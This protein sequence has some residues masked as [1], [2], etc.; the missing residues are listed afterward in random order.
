GI[1]ITIYSLNIVAWGGMLFLLLINAAPAMC[2]PSCNDISSSRRIWVEIDSQIL[3][4]LFCIPGFGLI[5]WRFRDLYLLMRYRIRGDT[6]AWEKLRGVHHTW[7]TWHGKPWKV[8]L[9]VHLYCFNT[10]FQAVLAG[11]MWGMTKSNRPAAGTGAAVAAACLVAMA[12]GWIEW[13]EGRKVKKA[14]AVRRRDGG[15]SGDAGGL[16]MSQLS[17]ATES[18]RDEEQEVKSKEAGLI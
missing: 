16:R 13:R 2:H 18:D 12:G 5:P 10:Y 3:N 17:R 14:R 1:L 15:E 9:V 11:L 6:P 4:A 7:N 8:D